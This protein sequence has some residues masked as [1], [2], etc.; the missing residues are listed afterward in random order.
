MA[1]ISSLEKLGTFPKG[2]LVY[3]HFSSF[4]HGHIRFL[5]AAK[6]EGEE[7][8]VALIG[9]E[10]KSLSQGLQFNQ[11]E[12][13]T[14]LSHIEL[15]DW[16]V[17]LDEDE[18]DLAVN[19]LK[20]KVLIFGK[21]FEDTT[22]NNIKKAIKNQISL[23]NEVKFLTGQVNYASTELLD[24]DQYIL[25]EKKDKQFCEAISNQ[26]ISIESLINN[27]EAMQNCRMMVIGDTIIDQYSACEAIGVSAEA[28]VIVVKELG[29]KYFLGGAAIVASHI[30]ALGAKPILI[31]LIGNDEIGNKTIKDLDEIGVKNIL[32]KDQNRPT[33]L[34]KR[35]CVENQKVF[36]VSK[37]EDKSISTEIEDKIINALEKNA[38]DCN[39]IIVSDFVY[40]LVTPN[41]ISAIKKI[42][43][44]YNLF[45][46]GDLQCSSQ[47]GDITKFEGF[48]CICPNEKEARI[49]LKDKD[50]GLESICQ[51]LIKKTKSKALMLTLGAEGLIAY[52]CNN[53]NKII[54]QAF[55]ALSVNPVD[56]SGAGDSLL[57][58]ISTS[59]SSGAPIMNAAILGTCM[60]SIAVQN[61]GN[62]S[63]KANQVKEKLLDILRN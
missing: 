63:I 26:N 39:G 40:G 4:H 20:P 58:I 8:I 54:R 44:K 10:A 47:L 7:L 52:D 5:K 12:R 14:I 36:R 35:Y 9:D 42:S 21:E 49:S 46:F 29:T 34:K 41:I 51:E 53:Q 22:S 23:K 37:L 30:K 25:K 60:S 1:N 56:V 18:I 19:K 6:D 33:T 55:P 32:I 28:P 62:K 17:M 31:S 50:S 15:I 27:L 45:V 24:N 61:M 59:I 16:I 3:G 43:E 57:A 48:S 13:A 38:K 2:V 11:S